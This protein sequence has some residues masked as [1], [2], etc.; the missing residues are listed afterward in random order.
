M[1][2]SEPTSQSRLNNWKSKQCQTIRRRARSLRRDKSRG[3][4]A[5]PL[6][7][8]K[9]RPKPRELR[10]PQTTTSIVGYASRPPL[11]VGIHQEVEI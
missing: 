10:T 2:D 5:Q 1:S 11:K 4:V 9:C 3:R 7:R 6:E 8:S